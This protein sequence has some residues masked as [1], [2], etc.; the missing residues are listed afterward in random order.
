MGFIESIFSQIETF[1]TN[2]G[3][4]Q[5]A[6]VAEA[7]GNTGSLVA[8]LAVL[9]IIINMGVQAVPVDR[10]ESLGL[11]FRITLVG[12]FMQSWPQFNTVMSALQSMFG[13]ME[14]AM[15]GAAFQNN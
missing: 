2:V 14:A 10:V 6:A 15:L 3:A 5:F 11:L 9:L 8:T 12:L 7:F 1:L 4:S 13:G